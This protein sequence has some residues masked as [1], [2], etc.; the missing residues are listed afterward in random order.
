[1]IEGFRIPQRS[2]VFDFAAVDHIAHGKLD[3]FAAACT[4]NVRHRND[5][6]R[7]VPRTRTGANRLFDALFERRG[8]FDAR[9]ESH[10]QHDLYVAAAFT[11]VTIRY[12]SGVR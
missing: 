8:Q 10:E 3:E 1:M 2:D 11:A 7:H 5:V 4:G 12:D 9:F 6:I